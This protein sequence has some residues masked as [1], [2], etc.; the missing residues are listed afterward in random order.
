LLLANFLVK[1]SSFTTKIRYQS[2]KEVLWH[3]YLFLSIDAILKIL[4]DERKQCGL[5]A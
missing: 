2:G 4:L 5:A 3:K 1:I